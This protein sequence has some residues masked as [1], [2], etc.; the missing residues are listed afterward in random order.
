LAE[1]EAAGWF[2]EHSIDLF[3]I[4][5]PAASSVSIARGRLWRD[6]RPRTSSINRCWTSSVQTTPN[7]FAQRPGR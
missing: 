6:G 7:G 1:S 2:F 5:K 3:V 4:A